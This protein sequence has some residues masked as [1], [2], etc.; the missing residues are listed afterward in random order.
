MRRRVEAK[1]LFFTYE[2]F[3]TY[4]AMMFLADGINRANLKPFDV[5]IPEAIIAPQGGIDLL[6]DNFAECEFTAR[7]SILAP[8]TSPFEVNWPQGV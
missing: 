4:T 8:Y 3:N 7:M 1:N 2:I 5:F 6:A